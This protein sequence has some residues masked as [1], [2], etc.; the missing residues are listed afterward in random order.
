MRHLDGQSGID[1]GRPLAFING[2][3]IDPQQTPLE[4]DSHDRRLPH[5]RLGILAL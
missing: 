4:A 3:H 5:T 1:R 2:S